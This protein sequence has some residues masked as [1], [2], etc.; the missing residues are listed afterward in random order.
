MT[1]S[2][3]GASSAIDC[4]SEFNQYQDGAWFLPVQSDVA[5]NIT[6]GVLKFADC[7]ALCP[8]ASDCQFVTYD[9]VAKTCTVRS[10]ASVV[11][12]G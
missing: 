6:S 2:R 1:V 5:T 7:V 11:Y 12:E 3:Q 8:A 9:Y 10:G 4:V